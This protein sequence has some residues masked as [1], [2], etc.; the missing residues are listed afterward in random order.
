ME[1]KLGILAQTQTKLVILAQ[2]QTN[3]CEITIITLIIPAPGLN[4][5]T[6]F[7]IRIFRTPSCLTI[8]AVYLF[9][10][11]E[12]FVESFVHTLSMRNILGECLFCNQTSTKQCSLNKVQCH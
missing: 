11:I 9:R 10:S 12:V 8:M 1:T 5:S 2:T 7:F 4:S 3:I 6:M